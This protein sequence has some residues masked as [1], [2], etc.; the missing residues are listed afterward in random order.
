M[1]LTGTRQLLPRT[2]HH[3]LLRFDSRDGLL[4]YL[5]DG[6]PE[7]IS[8]VTDTG[9]ESG[10]VAVPVLGA[11]YAAARHRRGVHRLPGRASRL[12][13]FVD[14]PV[15]SRFLGKTGT[16]TYPGSSTSATP[17]RASPASRRV[18]STPGD[19]GIE[20]SYQ[21]SD[22]WGGRKVA[23]GDTDWVPFVPGT[24]FGDTVKARYIQLRVELF[25]DGTRTQSPRLSSLAG[26]LRAEPPAG[27]ARRR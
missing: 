7:A 3:H 18:D 27:A 1:R 2:W 24:D 17:P 12:A 10:S 14:D 5:L 15:L 6:V 20:F 8:H 4:E 26:R 9:R 16:A 25:P 19:S 13:A 23:E 22:T 11:A 21:V